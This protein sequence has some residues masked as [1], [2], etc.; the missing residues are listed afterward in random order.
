MDEPLNPSLPRPQVLETG[1]RRIAYHSTLG[2]GPG[3]VFLGGFMSDMTGTKAMALEAHCRTQGRA[4]L[5]FDYTGHGQSSGKF[6]DGTIGAWAGDT[7]AVLDGLTQGP[8]VLAGSSMGGWIMTLT[9]LARPGRIAGLVGVAAAPD[10]T[11]DL[12]PPLM[13]AEQREALARDGVYH[14]PSDTGERPHPITKALLEDGRKHLVLRGDIPV[15][16]PVALVQGMKDAEVP[17]QTSIRLA[18]KLASHDVT[19]TLVKDGDHRM[20]QP[21]HLAY[22]LAALDG[23]LARRT[24]ARPRLR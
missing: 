17:Y 21:R 24:A 19:V 1:G 14:L 7:I 20:S 3:V 5:R 11:E 12:L 9:A 23:V 13:T 8:Q 22:L 6:A 18:E 16:C 4:F 2:R 10:F 15:S